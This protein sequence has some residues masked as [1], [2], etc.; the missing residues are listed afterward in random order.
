MLKMSLWF[1]YVV[2]GYSKMLYSN[3]CA[4]IRCAEE[5]VFSSVWT[6]FLSVA[7]TSGRK[8]FAPHFSAKRF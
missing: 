6:V 5:V 8:V 7:E 4:P 1:G 3:F 2:Q